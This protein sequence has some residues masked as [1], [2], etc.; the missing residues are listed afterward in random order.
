[1]AAAK[2]AKKK[3]PVVPPL[4]KRWETEDGALIFRLEVPKPDYEI[5]LTVED[6]EDEMTVELASDIPQI[7]E[8]IALLQK[9]KEVIQQYNRGEAVES[10]VEED[11]EIVIGGGV[12][13]ESE[14]EDEEDE[15]EEDEDEE[16][17]EDEGDE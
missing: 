2:T 15:D 11:E 17:E 7:D 8:L 16:D 9:A 14:D 1:M 13:E 4:F 10:D 3:N 12:A 6:P 5:D